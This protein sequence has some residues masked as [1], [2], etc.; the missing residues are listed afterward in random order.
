MYVCARVWAHERE[1]VRGKGGR[2][3][4]RERARAR[5]A[6]LVDSKSGLFFKGHRY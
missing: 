3:G 1:R 2:G 6:R 4:E 5:A